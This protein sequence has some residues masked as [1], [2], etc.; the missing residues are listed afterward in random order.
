MMSLVNDDQR[1]VIGRKTPPSVFAHHGLHGG[2]DD[3]RIKAGRAFGC[4]DPGHDAGGPQNLVSRLF[5]QFLAMGENK[6]APGLIVFRDPGEKQRLATAGGANNQLA[7]ELAKPSMWL[8]RLRWYGGRAKESR[9]TP[10]P[11]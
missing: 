6:S 5:E 2:N 8:Q 9:L 7:P 1:E 4:L 11:Q 3:R 10:V